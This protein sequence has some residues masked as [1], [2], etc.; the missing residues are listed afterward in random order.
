MS[1]FYLGEGGLRHDCDLVGNVELAEDHNFC[2]WCGKKV[3]K[4]IK[5]RIDRMGGSD[6]V[7]VWNE[8]R[9]QIGNGE[10]RQALEKKDFK[11][12]E[13]DGFVFQFEK[14]GHLVRGKKIE[15]GTLRQALERASW[16]GEWITMLL[17]GE[18]NA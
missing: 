12:S 17:Y 5:D 7:R 1:R 11:S 10:F 2:S 16:S 14:F 3:T 4:G 15:D 9:K 8:V 18:V 6:G 13:I